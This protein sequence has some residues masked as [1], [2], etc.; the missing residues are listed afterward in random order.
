MINNKFG[1]SL[2]RFKEL[3]NYRINESASV[4]EVDWD[5]EFSDVKKTCLS[6]EMVVKMLNDQL[7]RLNKPSKDREK[8]D[9]NTPIISRGNLPL[10]DGDIDVDYFIK[11]ITTKPKQIF[12]RNPKMEKSDTG[13]FQYTVNTG[14]PALRGIIYDID[15]QKFFTINTCPG[16]G[17]CAVSCYARKGFYIMNDG[18]N[19]KY[20]QR[21]NL[22]LNDP[23]EYEN[24]IMDEL[25]PLAYKIKRDSRKE[26]KDIKLVIRWN[27]AGDFFAKRYYDIAI[28]V[29]NQLVKAGYNIE[30]YAYTKMGDVANIADPNFVMNFSDDANKKETAK[31]DTESAKISKIVPKELFKDIFLKDGPSYVK[32]EKGKAMFKDE[33]S[34]ER[35]KNLISVKYNVPYETLAFNDELPPEQSSDYLYNVI[36]LPTGDSDIAAQRR[37]VRISFLLQH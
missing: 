27:D 35:L 20:I 25:D 22:L 21:L 4:N 34:K 8:I 28:S 29:T 31:V 23:E 18:K 37:D 7:S 30:S 17:T 12:D 32:D 16:A 13:G 19:L 33:A 36:V 5:E 1:D 6:P 10:A 26:G 14:I 3:Y 11:E 9:A 24:I 15:N 2:G